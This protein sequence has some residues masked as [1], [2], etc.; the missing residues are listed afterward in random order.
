MKKDKDPMEDKSE[1]RNEKPGMYRKGKL[2]LQ[3]IKHVTASFIFIWFLSFVQFRIDGN[4]LVNFL[5]L[6][7][8]K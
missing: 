2:I 4:V 3:L 7:S 1:W 8:F 6:K 5:S